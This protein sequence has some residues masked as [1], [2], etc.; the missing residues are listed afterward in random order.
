[1]IELL[2]A[3]VALQEA[4]YTAV[5]TQGTPK[6]GAWQKRLRAAKQ[7]VMEKA[8]D[9]APGDPD[10]LLAHLEA[11]QATA[12]ARLVYV[13]HPDELTLHVHEKAKLTEWA[14]RDQLRAAVVV[15]VKL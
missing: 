13:A 3:L 5:E 12:R 7:N 8:T 6:A 11:M 14:A 10:R 15:G 9:V 2:R 1:M 4:Q